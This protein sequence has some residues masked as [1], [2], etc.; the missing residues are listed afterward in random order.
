MSVRSPFIDYVV[1]LTNNR[2][3]ITNIIRQQPITAFILFLNR[4]CAR[5]RVCVCVCVL[6]VLIVRARAR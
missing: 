5:A 4:Q 2:K 1:R 3:N 6:C